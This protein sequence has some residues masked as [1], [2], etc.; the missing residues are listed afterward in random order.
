MLKKI[1]ITNELIKERQKISKAE[2]VIMDQVKSILNSDLVKESNVLENLKFYNKT[3]EL[4]DEEV[5]DTELIF[6][7]EEIKTICIKYRLRFLDSQFYKG[8]IPYESV[9]KIKDLNTR[10]RKDLKGFKILASRETFSLKEKNSKPAILFA[11]TLTGNYYLIHS[12]GEEYKW[13]RKILAFPMRTFESLMLSLLILTLIIDLSLPTRLITLDHSA[14]YWCGY[15]IASYFHLL[16]FLT[17][18]TAYFT[19]AFNKNFSKSDWNNPG[20]N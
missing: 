10:Y 4:L 11:K 19:F 17:G 2:D 13:Y 3:F 7:P 20:R 9:L 15:R 14:T 1:N 6:R 5:L 12:W 8:E 16:I 18:F